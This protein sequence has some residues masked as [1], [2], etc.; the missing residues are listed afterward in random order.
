V[1]IEENI[2]RLIRPLVANMD[3][4]SGVEPFEERARSMGFSPTEVVK[5]DGNENPYGPSP[6]V[7]RVLGQFAQYHLYPDPEQRAMRNA[8][9]AYSGTEAESVVVGSGADELIDLILRLFLEP[10]DVVVDCPPTFGMYRFSTHVCG[11]SVIT[12]PRDSKFHLDVE[13]VINAVKDG[14][15]VVF[16]AS[17]NNPTGNVTSVDDIR[18]ILQH[19]SLVVVDETYFEFSGKTILGLMPEN[20]NLIVLRSMSKWAGLAGLR[21]G[22]GIM[23]PN[24]ARTLLTIKPPYNVNRAGEVALMASLEDRDWLMGNVQKLIKERERLRSFLTAIAGIEAMPSDANFLLC[25][26]TNGHGKA[27]HD[28]LAQ[29]GVFVRYFDTPD[30]QEYIRVSAGLPEHSDRLITE[31][32]DIVQTGLLGS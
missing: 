12:V 29:R 4:Y 31:M 23:P 3:R 25:R 18:T 1:N 17:P 32:R 2:R 13:G 7:R 5:A 14:A 15:K 10:N 28:A 26:V 27:L 16:I 8:L 6:R 21:I 24:L 19:R 20:P 11:G 30:L 9:A 22:Y